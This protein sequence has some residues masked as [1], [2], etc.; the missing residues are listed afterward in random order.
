MEKYNKGSMCSKCGCKHVSTT[1]EKGNLKVD[2]SLKR[3]CVNCGHVWRELPLDSAEHIQVNVH[4][5]LPP[6]G[7]I[8][9]KTLASVP[10]P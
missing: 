3:R 2:D 7:E 1:F 5:N 8:D 10:V 4:V 9:E 6:L